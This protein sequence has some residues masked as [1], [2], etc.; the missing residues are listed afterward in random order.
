MDYGDFDAWEFSRY[1]DLGWTWH[2]YKP[3]GELRTA[4]ARSFETRDTCIE[5]AMRYGFRT[6]SVHDDVDAP[7]DTAGSAPVTVRASAP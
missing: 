7:F 1:D 4:S 2:R 3:N 6:V 5:D